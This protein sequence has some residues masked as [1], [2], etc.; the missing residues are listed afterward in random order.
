MKKTS[1]KR[2]ISLF[3]KYTV[4]KKRKNIVYKDLQE[5]SNLNK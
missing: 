1:G 4:F 5:I 3:K 2:N